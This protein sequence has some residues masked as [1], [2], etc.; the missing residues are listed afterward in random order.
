MRRKSI[1]E[2]VLEEVAP[3][4]E[5]IPGGIAKGMTLLDIA[6]KHS[7]KIEQIKSQLQKGIKIEMEHTGNVN[8]AKEIATDHLYEDGLYYD[9]LQQVNLE[10]LVRKVFK[11]RLEVSN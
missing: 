2:L 5:Y 8:V 3:E 10:E 6:K 11:K 9:K 1:I 7:L 4:R